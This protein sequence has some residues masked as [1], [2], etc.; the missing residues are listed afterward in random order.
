MYNSSRYGLILTIISLLLTLLVGCGREPK[1][2][3]APAAEMKEHYTMEDFKTITIGE[4]TYWDVYLVAPSQSMQV[5][6][7]GGICEYPMENGGRICVKFLG[8]D[9]IVG[10]IEQRPP[11]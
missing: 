4:S 3:R 1:L 5:T 6:S 10:T 2:H 9:L 7:Y 8:K 11:T